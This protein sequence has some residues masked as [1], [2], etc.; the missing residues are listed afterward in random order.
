MQPASPMSEL[1]LALW[2]D[3][4][5]V[6]LAAT[7]VLAVLL[8]RFLPADRA[9]VRH[10]LLLFLMCLLLEVVAAV[11]TLR[12]QAAIAAGLHEA[13]TLGQG[14]VLIRLAGLGLFRV[15]LPA[16]RAPTPRI[17]E[18]VVVIGGYLLWGLIRLS[19]AGVELS[20]LVA[21]SAV[22]TAVLAFAMQDTLGNILGGLALQLDNSLQIGDWVRVDEVCGRVVQIQWRY[23]A[24]L[25]RNGERV[26]VPNAQLMKGKFVVIGQP[27]AGA[28]GW[29][30][31]IG[32]NIEYG[33]S[34]SRVIAEAER[35]TAQAEIP[36]VAHAPPPATSFRSWTSQLPSG[37]S[38]ACCG[39]G[40]RTRQHIV[41]LV[42]GQ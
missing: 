36:N 17:V 33:A 2:R 19:W 6:L 42:Y 9:T 40:V 11:F 30:R 21:T 25:T 29:R 31:W 16:L 8:H 4:T 35:S 12:A 5:P 38:G 28:A 22:I 39:G 27:D 7:L 10:T 24:I 3:Q 32:F 23:T 1:F 37:P 14:V 18:D 15:L 41:W 20:S 34:P 13:A 26:V